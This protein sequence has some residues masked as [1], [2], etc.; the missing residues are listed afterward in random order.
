M[1]ILKLE[2]D[3]SGQ[4]LESRHE[5]ARLLAHAANEYAQAGKDAGFLHDVNGNHCGTW[6]V[7]EDD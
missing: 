3:L 7:E 4:A 2:I 6:W 1:A 5:V